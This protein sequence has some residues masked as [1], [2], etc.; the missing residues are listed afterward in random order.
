MGTLALAVGIW[1]YSWLHPVHVSLLN[2]DLDLKTGKIEIVFKF[3]A[4]DFNRII[5]NKYNVDL[6]LTDKVD[7]GDKIEVIHKYLDESF[8][9]SI[10]GTEIDKWEYTGNQIDETSIWLYFSN[11]WPD[12]IQKISIT[13]GVMMDLYE[14]QTNL[15]IVNWSDQQN[16]YRLDN[17][18]R[19]I[20]FILESE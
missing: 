11:L 12:K 20:S 9:F 6:D 3:F 18:N 13:D 15:V 17:K 4:D 2:I 14:D 10:N 16:G 1:F 19:E 7:P 8:R 5:L